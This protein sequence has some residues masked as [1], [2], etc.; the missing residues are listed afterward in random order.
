MRFPL[1]NFLEIIP[2]RIDNEIR[3]VKLQ[4]IPDPMQNQDL[5]APLQKHKFI[6]RDVRSIAKL[7]I[8]PDD[9]ELFS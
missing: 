2:S 3:S 4:I 9:P 1:A 6:T 7:E 8:N 5:I